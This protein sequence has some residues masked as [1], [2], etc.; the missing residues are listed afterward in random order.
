MR[1]QKLRIIAMA[2]RLTEIRLQWKGFNEAMDNVAKATKAQTELNDQLMMARKAFS[3]LGKTV[4]HEKP[5]CKFKDK[6][7]N[8]FKR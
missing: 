7:K 8:N 6:P 1:A 3:D 4:I 2:F 5:T